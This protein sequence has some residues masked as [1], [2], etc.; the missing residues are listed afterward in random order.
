MKEINGLNCTEK[1]CKFSRKCAN[2]DSAGDYRSEGGFTPEIIL[3]DDKIFCRTIERNAEINKY[4]EMYPE[5]Y[6]ELD[7][8]SVFKNEK[9]HLMIYQGPGEEIPYV[10]PEEKEKAREELLVACDLLEEKGLIY[11]ANTLR[12]LTE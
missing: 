7:R 9:G 2:H 10:L 6:E 3:K 5:N 8:G 12:K 11:A 4:D 1:H